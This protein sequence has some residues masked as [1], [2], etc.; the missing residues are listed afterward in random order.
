MSEIKFGDYP[1]YNV[2]VEIKR[3]SKD[4]KYQIQKYGKDELSRAIIL[5]A[6]HNLDNTPRNVDVIELD[7]LC[8]YIGN[9]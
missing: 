4:Y 9:V 8:N 6:I 7:T 2:P 5:C 1:I 3:Y